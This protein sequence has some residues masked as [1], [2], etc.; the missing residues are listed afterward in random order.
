M[1][2]RLHVVVDPEYHQCHI[3]W[4]PAG[5]RLSRAVCTCSWRSGW[6]PSTPRAVDYGLAHT[7]AA[8]EDQDV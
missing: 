4:E 8:L 5:H 3:E 6:T 7:A 1:T 2:A